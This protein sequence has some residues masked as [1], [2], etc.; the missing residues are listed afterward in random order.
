MSPEVMSTMRLAMRIAVVFP[1]P[2]GP[3][4][5]QISPAATSS[6]SA[7]TAG[8]SAPGYTLVASR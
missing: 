8:A 6:V 3:T 5:T 1:Q 7:S 4:R 2:E